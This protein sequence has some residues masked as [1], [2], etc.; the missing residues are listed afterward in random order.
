MPEVYTFSTGQKLFLLQGDLLC[1]DV[2]AIVNAANAYLQHGGGVAGQ[3]VRRGGE[4]IQIESD[5][6]VQEK[7][8]VSH[9]E[10]AYTSAG[11]LNFKYIIHAVGPVWGS[12]NEE[13]KLRQAIQGSLRVAD[14][15][16]LSS[17]G[18]PAISTGIF[19][20][21]VSKAAHVFFSS[22]D[23]YYHNHPLSLLQIIKIALF[24]QKPYEVFLSEFYSW[25]K[26]KEASE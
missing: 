26:L 4:V 16:N 9:D 24:D 5:R 11:S 22:I 2:D 21:P 12:G 1:L 6:W 3:I 19:G 13:L 23:D 15:L 14:R 8:I 20:F 18:F 25:K 10:P 7:G 17:L